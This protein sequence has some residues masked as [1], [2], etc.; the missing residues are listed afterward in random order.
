MYDAEILEFDWE[1]VIHRQWA[2]DK[3]LEFARVDLQSIP[4]VNSD[5]LTY[6][7]NHLFHFGFKVGRATRKKRQK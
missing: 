3:K 6:T 2:L 5:P 7:L 1:L 4:N